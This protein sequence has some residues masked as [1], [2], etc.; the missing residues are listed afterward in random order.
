MQV[1]FEDSGEMFKPPYRFLPYCP[2]CGAERSCGKT[3][4]R[5][6]SVT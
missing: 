1:V 2:K 5:A 4:R 6:T 3:N